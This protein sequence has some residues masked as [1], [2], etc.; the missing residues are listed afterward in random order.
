MPENDKPS[1]CSFCGHTEKKG[2]RLVKGRKKGVSI[3]SDCVELCGDLLRD[4][5]ED[6]KREEVKES[7]G[8]GDFVT[9]FDQAGEVNTEKTIERVV[10][11]FV[12]LNIKHIVVATSTGDTAIKVARACGYRRHP[13]IDYPKIIAVTLH[14]GTWEKY[15]APDTDKVKEAEEIGVKFLTCT[16]ALMGNVGNAIM[17]K[18]GGVSLTDLIAHTYYTFSQGVKVAVEIAVM[19]ADAGLIPVDQEVISVAGSDSGA[20]TA[21]VI[22]PAY[23]TDFFSL[24]VRELIAKPR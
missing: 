20:D 12:G 3:C 18:F 2:R 11:R 9:Y 1:V 15:V 6:K 19:A 7:M 14:A 17:E 8:P 22:K 21:L 4:E 5:P 13:K 23:S 24:R 16:H 10:D